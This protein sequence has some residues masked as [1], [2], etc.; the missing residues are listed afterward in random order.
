MRAPPNKEADIR[1]LGA[2]QASWTDLQLIFGTRGAASRCWCQR[3]K[4]DPGDSFGSVPAEDRAARLR[5]QT[6]AGQPRSGSTS[7]LV[8]YRGR[9]PVGWC[10]LEPRNG[11]CGLVRVFEVPW[12]GRDEDRADETVWAVTCVL[13]RVGFR[14]QGVSRALVRAAV[15]HARNH[16]ARAIEGYPIRSENAITEELHVGTEATFAAAGF[17]LVGNPTVRRVVMRIDF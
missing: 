1:V 16:G 12:Q 17:R 13:A 7:G 15:G 9:D 4:L 14:K 3:Y 8:A 6:G 10:A 5:D 2:N 11:Y